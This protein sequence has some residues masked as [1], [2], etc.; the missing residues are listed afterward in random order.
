MAN[1]W[2]AVKAAQTPV[3]AGA[4][5]PW[6]K[7]VTDLTGKLGPIIGAVS[8]VIGELGSSVDTL[9]NS[10]SV[11]R[12]PRFHRRDRLRRR[13]RGRERGDRPD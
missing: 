10:E 9:I 11:H 2:Q 3:V 8:P 1:A 5:Q 4:L 6:L 7:S 12:V 13:V